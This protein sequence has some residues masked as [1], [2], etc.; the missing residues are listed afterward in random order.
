MKILITGGN[1]QLGYDMALL[2]K[3]NN[4]PYRAIDIEECDLTQETAV[5]TYITT[6]APTHVI[7]CAAYTAVDKAESDEQTCYSV[8]VLATE[9]VAKACLLIDATLIYISTDYVFHGD[10]DSPLEVDAPKAPLSVYG[11]TKYEGEQ[12]VKAWLKKYYIVRTSWIF[13]VYGNNFVKTMLRLG[14]EKDTLSVVADQI[15]SPTYT[16][17]LAEFLYALLQTKRYGVYHATN[18]GFCSWYEFAKTI[19]E[20]AKLSCEV[21]P[22]STSEYPTPAKRPHN[23]RLSKQSIVDA[24]LPLLPHWQQ[25]LQRFL[26]EI[27]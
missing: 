10:G 8:N 12:V 11:K 17:D 3:R 7:H 13:G 26:Q 25:A 24:G 2:L 1:G 19:M 20:Y 22:V 15:G 21:V 16:P 4:I 9:N 23:S 5:M 27:Q 14:N 6:Y 18:E